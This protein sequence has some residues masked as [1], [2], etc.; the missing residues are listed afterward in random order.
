MAV[1]RAAIARVNQGKLIRIVE[2]SVMSNHVHLI[3][4]AENSG[5]LSKGMASLNTG[6]GFL[7]PCSSAMSFGGFAERLRDSHS[8]PPRLDFLP[9][10]SKAEARPKLAYFQPSIPRRGAAPPRP[11]RLL[12]FLGRI[13]RSS[14][15]QRFQANA[16]CSASSLSVSANDTVLMAT[17]MPAMSITFFLSRADAFPLLSCEGSLRTVALPRIRCA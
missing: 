10:S 5:D 4:E 13:G 7:D 3:A 1:V 17:N 14:G 12:R 8:S 2:F 16:Q 15:V 9:T 11:S 6:L